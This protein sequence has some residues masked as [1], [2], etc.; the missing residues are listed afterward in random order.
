M[1]RQLKHNQANWIQNSIQSVTGIITSKNSSK[2]SVIMNINIKNNNNN[3]NKFS[4]NNNYNN[5]MRTVI[6]IMNNNLI[7]LKIKIMINNK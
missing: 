1:I 3:K 6:M 7:L 4:N 2:I 5:M